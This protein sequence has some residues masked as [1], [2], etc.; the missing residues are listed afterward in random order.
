M[1]MMK[2]SE[3]TAVIRNVSRLF[4]PL[5]HSKIAGETARHLAWVESQKSS[6]FSIVWDD[7]SGL[8]GHA[9]G[10]PLVPGYCHDG[11]RT[12]IAGKYFKR[13]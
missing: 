2:T 1:K 11:V 13:E 12:G 7:E 10:K 6:A 5:K 9:A 4:V 3:F 8:P